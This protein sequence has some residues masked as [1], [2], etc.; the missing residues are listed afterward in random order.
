VSE[1]RQLMQSNP[2]V[3]LA[4][5][6]PG[7]ATVYLKE[8]FEAG[9]QKNT[10]LLFCDGTKSVEM[11][12]ALGANN[13]AGYFGTAAGSVSG[14]S[15]E[16]FQRD[17][18]AKYGELPPLPYMGS[19][20]DAIVVAA[21][22]AAAA[23]AEGKTVNGVNLRDMLRK[24]SNPPGEIVVAGVDGFKEALEL[25]QAGQDINYE[26]VAGSQDFDEKGDVVTPIEVWKYIETEPYIETVR[27]E[28][29]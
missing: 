14:D 9:Y 4:L 21:L 18:T 25:L 5:G 22:A 19:F 1:L 8:F 24:V 10:F 17:Y 13:M 26:G 6:Y 28:R 11:P 29:P 20:Y 2:D 3:M 23:Q 27:I 12:K 15:Q 7:Q 16:I